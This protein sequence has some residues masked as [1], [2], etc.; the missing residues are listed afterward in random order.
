MNQ[1]TPTPEQLRREAGLAASIEEQST[2]DVSEPMM[3]DMD[4]PGTKRCDI[5]GFWRDRTYF[6][7][8]VLPSGSRIAM[9]KQ[10]GATWSMHRR[11]E[12]RATGDAR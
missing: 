1:P 10:C 9:C 8:R 2:I 6:T 7:R 11:M 12:R 5:C 3:D 4:D